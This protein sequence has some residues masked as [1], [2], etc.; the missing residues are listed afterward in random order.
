MAKLN[1]KAISKITTPIIG[2]N[3]DPIE[4]HEDYQPENGNIVIYA[5]GYEIYSAWNCEY[6]DEGFW[7]ELKPIGG[8]NG[9]GEDADYEL[10]AYD[11][12]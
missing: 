4:A 2:F 8:V 10:V 5:G 1:Y 9:N 12:L 6:A 11:Y 7:F 3:S